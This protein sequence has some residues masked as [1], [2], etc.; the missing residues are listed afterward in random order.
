[1]LKKTLLIITILTFKLLPGCLQSDRALF[2]QSGGEEWPEYGELCYI[3]PEMCN[4]DD[5]GWT[6]DDSQD[7]V[8]DHI[9]GIEDMPGDPESPEYEE[10]TEDMD[11]WIDD[12]IDY[13]DWNTDDFYNGDGEFN[14][15]EWFEFWEFINDNNNNPGG[16]GYTPPVDSVYIKIDGQPTKYYNGD[17]IFVPQRPGK[18]VQLLFQRTSSP[19]ST[20]NLQWKLN[21]APKCNTTLSCDFD[22]STIGSSYIRIDSST[23]FRIQTILKVYKMPTLHYKI[24]NNYQGEYGFDDSSH[25]HP[26]IRYNALYAAGTEVTHING[27]TAYIVPWLSLLNN[28]TAMIRDT[29][30]DLSNDAKKDKNAYVKIVS[31]AVSN[32]DISVGG[33]LNGQFKKTFLELSLQHNLQISAQQWDVNAEVNKTIGNLYAIT[34]TGDT[35]GKLNVSCVEPVQKKIVLV[36]VNIGTGMNPTTKQSILDSLNKHSHNQILRR[37]VLDTLNSAA[38]KDTIDL[39]AEYNSNPAKFGDADTLIKA[40]YI[41]S[42]YMRHKHTDMVDSVN[43]SPGT[44]NTNDPAKVHF[45]FIFNYSLTGANH[46]L[47][48]TTPGGYKSLWWRDAFFETR[49]HELGHILLLKHTF[50]T[51]LTGFPGYNIPQNTT[52]NFMDYTPLGGSNMFYFAQWISTY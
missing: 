38:G 14:W 29:V 50:S 45:A 21:T 23:S 3:D 46:V 34:N 33:Q 9:P 47:G 4:P 51:S 17:T 25:T 5:G 15:D 32:N 40:M 42:F 52:K 12:W 18:T 36:Y 26:S 43:G 39:T 13:N 44:A 27:D 28:D 20:T 19:P 1:M 8:D 30:L 31:D 48:I 16:G 49:A 37:W 2:A 11:I 10:W 6:Y 41:D 24:G 35:I 7:W 22:V